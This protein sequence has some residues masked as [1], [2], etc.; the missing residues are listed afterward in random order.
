[1]LMA[2][3]MHAQAEAI[4]QE[5]IAGTTK[6]SAE[7]LIDLAQTEPQLIII[8]SRKHSDHIKGHIEGSINLPDTETTAQSLASHIPGKSTPVIFYCNGI[9]C[10][11]S[12]AAA[13]IAVAAGYS[14]IYWFRGGWEEWTEKGYPAAR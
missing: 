9:R 11:R 13:K 6:I 14:K 12:A 10:A 1:M 8:D 2:F 5:S 3:W 7:E 4:V